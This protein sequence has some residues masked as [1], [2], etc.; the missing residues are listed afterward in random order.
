MRRTCCILAFGLGLT[1]W[2]LLGLFAWRVH[3]S[4]KLTA[5][6][7]EI[8]GHWQQTVHHWTGQNAHD[9]DFELRDDHS[10]HVTYR[11][12]QNAETKHVENAGR[13]HV[14]G[15]NIIFSDGINSDSGWLTK[16]RHLWRF[17]NSRDIALRIDTKHAST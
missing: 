16:R 6:E 9:A 12:S 17:S 2:L 13:W 8:V 3:E 10:L 14:E 5:A 1:A 4:D 15:N 7:E 11:N